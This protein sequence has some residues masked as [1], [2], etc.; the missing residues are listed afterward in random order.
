MRFPESN[1]EFISQQLCYC[2]FRAVTLP[3]SRKTPRNDAAQLKKVLAKALHFCMCHRRDKE[4]YF[5]LT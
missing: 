4:T 1:G 5:R 2:G 3:V